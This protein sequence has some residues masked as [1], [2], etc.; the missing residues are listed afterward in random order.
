M[1]KEPEPAGRFFTAVFKTAVGSKGELEQ[2]SFMVIQFQITFR[3]GRIDVCFEVQ[4]MRALR[5]P[6]TAQSLTT[7][8]FFLTRR[9]KQ[10]LLASTVLKKLL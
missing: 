8:F 6:K 4:A 1:K 3:N 5:Q 10:S 7:S 9:R 2:L